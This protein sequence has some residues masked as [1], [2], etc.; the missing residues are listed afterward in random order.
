MPKALAR[1]SLPAEPQEKPHGASPLRGHVALVSD[2]LRLEGAYTR[3]GADIAGERRHRGA[4][5]Q[6]LTDFDNRFD[7]LFTALAGLLPASDEGG[8]APVRS[9]GV[10]YAR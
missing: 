9:R 1:L 2:L 5:L 4:V 8:A 10:I 3:L 6:D 7:D